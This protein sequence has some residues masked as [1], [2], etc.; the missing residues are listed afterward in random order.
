[1]KGKRIAALTLTLSLL[2]TLALP[3]SAV[4]INT[5]SGTVAGGMSHTLALKEDGTVLAWGSNRQLQLGQDKS[6]EEA[7]TPVEVKGLSAVAVAAGSD[8][9]AALKYDGTV[10]VWGEGMYAAPQDIGLTGVVDIAAGMSVLLALKSDGTVWQYSFGGQPVQ[11]AGLSRVAAVSAGNGHYLALTSDGQV[12]AWGNNNYG[13]LG[14]GTTTG[15]TVPVRVPGLVDIVDVAAGLS[16][17]LAAGYNGAVYAWGTNSH[18]ELGIGGA[19]LESSSTPLVVKGITGAVQVAA[20]NESS[21]ALTGKGEVYTWGYG[22]Y[23]QLGNGSNK[24]SS[25][26][27]V[28]VGITQKVDYIA[29]GVYHNMAMTDTGS[30]YAWGRNQNYQLGNNKNDNFNTPQRVSGT[31]SA[32][33]GYTVDRL[34]TV[35]AW[36]KADAEKLSKTQLVPP[37]LWGN[38]T[39]NITRAEFAHLLVSV[40]EQVKHTTASSASTKLT[41]YTDIDGHALAE[42]MKKA[43]LL[44]ILNGTSDTTLAPDSLITREQAAKMLCSF[45]AKMEGTTIPTQLQNLGFYSD[46]ASISQWAVPYVYYAY[47]NDIMK[48]TDS[49]FAPL[50]SL[51]REQSLVTMSRLVERY[52]W[53]A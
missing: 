37:M 44:G 14:D 43:Y 2:A 15:R 52:Q 8:F 5:H 23:G 27:P 18:G 24:T 42:D 25:A 38:Y 29:A 10:Y 6:V 32:G 20:G 51:T 21:M 3:A 13:Q 19:E 17:S 4:D 31:M 50:S 9:S 49:G 34:D 39:A 22:E 28:S 7:K 12:Y 35:S 40:Y 26:T 41:Q 46:A 30:L 48:G 33:A 36:A 1:M 45:V 47:E 53:A 11:V 16:H